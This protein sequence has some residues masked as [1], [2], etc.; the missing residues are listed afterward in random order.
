MG[1]DLIEAASLVVPEAPE[2]ADRAIILAGLAAFNRQFADPGETGPL[3]VLLQT[4]AGTTVGGLWGTTLFRWLRIE[5]VFV[6]AELRGA[7]VGTA[8]LRRAEE[9][10]IGRGCIGACLDTYS[11]QAR[12]FYEKLGYR[13]AGTIED[14]P[15]AGAHH[16]LFK[17][18]RQGF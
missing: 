7:S 9:L 15:P 4:A 17:R 18:F 8:I 12:G 14:C 16:Y 1:G 11:F 10:A 13:L 2:E 5:L 3:A 6:P